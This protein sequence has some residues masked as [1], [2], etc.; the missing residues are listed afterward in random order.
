MLSF[1]EELLFPSRASRA[2][3]VCSCCAIKGSGSLGPSESESFAT[4][5]QPSSMVIPCDDRRILL[6]VFPCCR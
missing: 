5:S 3:F 1:S 6:V 4:T 2:Q